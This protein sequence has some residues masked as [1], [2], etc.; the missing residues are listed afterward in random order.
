MVVPNWNPGKLL[1]GE[2][3]IGVSSVL[4]KSGPVVIKG[5]NDVLW[6]WDT[7]DAVAI[8]VVSVTGILVDVVSK[9]DNVVDRFLAGWVAESVEISKWVVGTAVNGQTDLCGVVV[10]SWRSLGLTNW[11]GV[12]GVTN[13]ELVIVLSPGLESLGLDLDGVVNVGRSVSSSVARDVAHV[14]AGG[15]L[16]L[17]TNWCSGNKA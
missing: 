10:W 15:D 6:L 1:V 7:V 5:E 9:M 17:D 13:V 2:L 3:K 12:V 16:V 4:S 14:W 8:S 11:G